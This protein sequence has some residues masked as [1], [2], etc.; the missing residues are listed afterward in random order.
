MRNNISDAT[1]FMFLKLAEQFDI[2]DM[3]QEANEYVLRNFVTTSESIEFKKLSKDALIYYL[4]HDE[5]NTEGDESKVFHAA[6]NW[7]KH[8][9]ERMQYAE[10]I[11]SSV[12]FNSIK[13]ETLQE[14]GETDLI[15]DRKQC[16]SLVRNALTYNALKYRKPLGQRPRGKKGIF[17]IN[18][19]D[20]TSNDHKENQ[21]YVVSLLSGKS[22]NIKANGKFHGMS[23]LEVNNFLF[24]FAVDTDTFLPVTMRYDPINNEWLTLAPVPT[25]KSAFVGSSLAKLGDNIIY[26]LGKHAKTES[27]S[28]QVFK[29]NIATNDWTSLPDMPTATYMSSSV[30]C[31]MND[32]VYVTGGF[33]H[34]A[35]LH[36][37][38]AYDSK[39]NL[40]IF[41]P[42]MNNGR[43]GHCL[44]LVQNILYAIGG[45]DVPAYIE[46]FDILSEQ[47]TD[48]KGE[49]LHGIGACSV[50]K[51]EKIYI[52]GGKWDEGVTGS[53]VIRVF[54]T[55]SEELET[56]EI[57]LQEPMCYHVCGLITHPKL[58]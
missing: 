47:W 23:M 7:L 44:E 11:M 6:K 57:S 52:I 25:G 22:E 10:E 14:I 9:E 28:K 58:L 49:E 53:S 15:D 19:L 48:I 16:R 51:D 18:R 8:D 27:L 39:A 12:R 42:P 21:S 5:L 29:Y 54:D 45:S 32:C 24:L 50:V 55:K 56:L 30:G 40:W 34:P 1:C 38:F 46:T 31:S 4:N 26:I 37:T 17:V 36:M 13:V 35:I 41:K 43:F 2:Q 33:V 3:R 20:G